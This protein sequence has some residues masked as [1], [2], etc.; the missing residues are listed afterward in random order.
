MASRLAST[1]LRGA[2][3]IH[4]AFHALASSTAAFPRRVWAVPCRASHGPMTC[5]RHVGHGPWG[6]SRSGGGGGRSGHAS[7][8]A[9]EDTIRRA[10]MVLGARRVIDPA[11]LWSLLRPTLWP[12][13]NTSTAQSF[14]CWRAG[15][16]IFILTDL[17]RYMY[18]AD[19]SRMPPKRLRPPRCVSTGPVVVRLAGMANERERERPPRGPSQA[20]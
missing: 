5:F 1:L 18:V 6:Q 7:D 15:A 14:S 13:K 8:G 19:G 4:L 20:S 3:L 10:S 11:A 12:D 9:S 16:Q 2:L 17:L